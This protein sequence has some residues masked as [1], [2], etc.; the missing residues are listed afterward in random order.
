MGRRRKEPDSSIP[1]W[2]RA[3]LQHVTEADA[4]E[5]IE[6]D[7]EEARRERLTRRS[8]RVARLLT[9]LDALEMAFVLLLQRMRD[10]REFF[11]R[12]MGPIVKKLQ[13]APQSGG[14]ANANLRTEIN[15]DRAVIRVSISAQ[16]A[17]LRFGV[18]QHQ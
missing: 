14:D 12:Q 17:E 5:A 7:L 10:G 2:V 1:R 11:R 13:S 16:G 8:A 9:T 15:G 18:P 4:L 3:I 6:G